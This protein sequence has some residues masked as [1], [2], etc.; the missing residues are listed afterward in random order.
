RI[1]ARHR[2][3]EDHADV[4][5]DDLPPLGA[6]QVQNVP[7][8]EADIVG[9]HRGRPWQQAHHRQ[10][11][12]GFARAGFTDNGKHLSLVD[13]QRDA[14][15]RLERSAHGI[16]GNGEVLDVQQ[17]HG[18]D[19]F[20]FG[21]SASRSPSP[22]RLMA[23]TVT[24]IA[25][26]GNVTTHQARMM[27]SRASASIVPHSGVGGCAPMPRKPRAAASRMALEKDRVAWTMSGAVQFGRMV[28]NIR[29]N[30]LAPATLAAVT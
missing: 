4:V 28:L 27:N 25:S 30:L 9:G 15:D 21:S 29:R 1:E 17:S 16:E 20:S 19:L 3:L 14:V 6:G 7:A 13:M 8:I 18:Q 12:D 11:G 26:P 24:R 2:L 5:A 10:H 23:S 22:I